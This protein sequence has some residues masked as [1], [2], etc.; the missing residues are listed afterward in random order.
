MIDDNEH[1]PL[2]VAQHVVDVMNDVIESDAPRDEKARYLLEHLQTLLDRRTRSSII[3]M[4]HL[5]RTPAPRFVQRIVFAASP[6]CK[7]VFDTEE[8]QVGADL[9]SPVFML[10]VPHL[11]SRPRVPFVMVVGEDAPD[12][13][14]VE[15][16]FR[17][18]LEEA[19]YADGMLGAWAERPDRAIALL[20]LRRLGTPEFSATDRSTMSLMLRAIAP[21]VDREI[22]KSDT[23][24]EGIELTVR[25]REV[26][27]LLL[28][29][30]SEKEIARQLHRS[31]HTV[32]TFVKQ[33]H[34]KFGVSS[35]G[36]LMAHFIDEAVSRVAREQ[37]NRQTVR[38]PAAES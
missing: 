14:W 22:F 9:S 6:E 12:P 25:Q 29:G 34:E 1:I 17:P 21:F 35:R 8:M 2:C 33:L 32:H 28:A 11:L 19:G 13:P 30:D 24:L 18:T 16:V 23:L 15:R 37:K 5:D 31:I 4:E 38:R 7:P 3:L 27:L 26:L 36:E 20:V 10:V